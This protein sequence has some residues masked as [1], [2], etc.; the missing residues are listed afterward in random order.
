MTPL[1][2]HQ[3]PPS[4]LKAFLEIRRRVHKMP[5]IPLEGVDENNQPMV[6]SCHI[7]AMA[8]ERF[9][10]EARAQH[11]HY[12]GGFQ[13]SWNVIMFQGGTFLIDPYPIACIGGPILLDGGFPSPACTLY[14]PGTLYRQDE[15]FG[16]PHFRAAVEKAAQILVT[17]GTTNWVGLN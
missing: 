17:M 4:V 11:G 15:K 14:Q 9:C 6:M 2:Y 3:V 16:N 1:Y 7:L 12:A 13:H 10:P 5:D 8:V